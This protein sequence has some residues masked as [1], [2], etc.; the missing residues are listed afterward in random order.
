MQSIDSYNTNV[1]DKSNAFSNDKKVKK[2]KTNMHKK[3]D[4]DYL[5]VLKEDPL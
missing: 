1:L 3:M 4:T 2:N 5:G